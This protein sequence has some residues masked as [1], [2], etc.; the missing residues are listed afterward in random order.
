MRHQKRFK[1]N[2]MLKRTTNV[3]I[4]LPSLPLILVLLI[5][6][7]VLVLVILKT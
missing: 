5:I 3:S 6:L 4:G 2:K 1:R 7:I